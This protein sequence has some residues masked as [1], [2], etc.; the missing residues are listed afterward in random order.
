MKLMVHS[1]FIKIF[2]LFVGGKQISANG[3]V[4]SLV[5]GMEQI[6]ISH[7]WIMEQIMEK[8]GQPGLNAV[9]MAESGSLNG[10]VK[11]GVI[12][13]HQSSFVYFPVKSRMQ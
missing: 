9:G 6:V 4:S 7:V 8:I 1:R 5:Q 12:R 3:N 2:L 11:A 10:K 13:K